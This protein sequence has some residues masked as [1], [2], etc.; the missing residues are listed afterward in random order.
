LGINVDKGLDP[1]VWLGWHDTEQGQLI[2]N[3]IYLDAKETAIGPGQSPNTGYPVTLKAPVKIS[4]ALTT[5]G[6]LVMDGKLVARH[7]DG[8]PTGTE[9]ER[10]LG[11]G[12]ENASR[13]EIGKPWVSETLPD[14]PTW[15]KGPLKAEKPA[16]FQEDVTILGAT[17]AQGE[18]WAN[19][20]VVPGTATIEE[21]T[22]N[23]SITAQGVAST[24]TAP[25]IVSSD[26]LLSEGTLQCPGMA[27]VKPEGCF[28][29]VRTSVRSDRNDSPALAVEHLTQNNS[30]A[31][32]HVVNNSW[33]AEGTG[34]YFR[35]PRAIVAEGQVQIN[36]TAVLSGQGVAL[37]AEGDVAIN[38]RAVLNG[39]TLHASPVRMQGQ[40]I[41]M[42]GGGESEVKMIAG[43]KRLEFYIGEKMTF[44]ID[45]NG[46]HNA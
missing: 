32:L 23:G 20:L 28:A 40:P 41:I 45:I 39:E 2:G 24:V 43:D 25:R 21:L 4:G 34:G 35:A 5:N 37:V 9:E 8:K 3:R 30:Q 6:E 10:V 17:S 29:Y 7:V 19:S 11:V 18:V 46:G 38:G 22:C 15:V 26:V 44:Y 1:D 13:V 12:R 36:G 27:E 16:T 31:A 14:I 42:G 33:L